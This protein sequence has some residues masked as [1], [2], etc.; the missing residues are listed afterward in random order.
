[1]RKNSYENLNDG[2]VNLY[3]E[4]IFVR[5]FEFSAILVSEL[6][7]YRLYANID[8]KTGFIFLELGFPKGYKEKVIKDLEI[9]GNF[10]R[11]I[12]K[13]GNITETIG[14]NKL[15]KDSEKLINLKTNLIKF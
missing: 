8:R 12:D 14:V 1:M 13:S 9:R 3:K 15:D 7:G 2:F 5:C 11:I 6:T 10:I 4:G